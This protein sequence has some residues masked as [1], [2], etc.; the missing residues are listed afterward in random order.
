MMTYLKISL[1]VAIFFVAFVRDFYFYEDEKPE[2]YSVEFIENLKNR[3]GKMGGSLRNHE[4]IS[5]LSVGKRDF[6]PEFRKALAVTGTMH[7]V[8][9]SA[10]HTGIMVLIF[11]AVFKT[12][13]FFTP[14]RHHIKSLVLFFLRIAASAY[15]FF[16]TGASIPTLRSLA[17][18]LF[19]DFFVIFG[20]FPHPVFIFLCSLASVA[21]LI[22]GSIAS[23]S[24]IMS[25]LC[26]ATVIKIWRV[27]PKS[28]IV[29][30]VCVSISIN[31]ALLATS[32]EL[33]GTFSVASPFVN[34]FVIPTVSL[35]V[36]FVTVAQFLIPFSETAAFF[37]LNTAD[38]LLSPASFLILFFSDF[39][40]KTSFPVVQVPFF[41]K[42]LFV[43][44]FFSALYFEK[45]IK[46]FSIIINVLA[47]FCFF[48]PIFSDDGIKRAGSFDGRAF[49]VHENFY[50]G[51]IF[52][53]KYSR[54]PSFNEYFYS[55][56]ERFSAECGITKV[57]S[58]HF[59]ESLTEG[60]E[61]RLRKK[62]RFK[63][64]KFYSRE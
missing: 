29:S 13:L 35:S 52:F 61:K 25:A 7:L 4:F 16:I 2:V 36:P 27:L 64:A 18:F 58:V 1:L 42:T 20:R 33:S 39:A 57:L 49:C 59:P 63:K 48:V 11:G 53:D 6:S 10:F 9:I 62:I 34:F 55:N 22:P 41:L 47:M 14:F 23:L 8:A 21:L 12:L 46:C 38:F 15:Y 43:A 56:I 5:A 50:S 17:F 60:Q 31:F 37:A 26:V 32:G 28:L 54:N 3:L 24:F 44:S 30:I 19:F 40:E 45:K 51:R